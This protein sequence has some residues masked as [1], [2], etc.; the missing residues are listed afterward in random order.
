MPIDLYNGGGAA[1][2]CVLKMGLQLQTSL[3]RSILDV[4]VES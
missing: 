4:S 1:I 2:F 3:V